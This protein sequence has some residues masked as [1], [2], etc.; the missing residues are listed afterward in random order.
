MYTVAVHGMQPETF[1][2]RSSAERYIRSLTGLPVS[3]ESMQPGEERALP[4]MIVR[5]ALK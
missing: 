1:R 2:K 3:L 4:G 5:R